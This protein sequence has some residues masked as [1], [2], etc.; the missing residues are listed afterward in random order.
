MVEE[1]KEKTGVQSEE[2][3]NIQEI[4]FRYLIHW[5][6]FVV[7]VIVCVALAWG[8][9]RLTT[10]VYNISATVLIKDEK[11]G[12]GANM[13][14]ELEKMG[15]N[16]FV[17]SSSNIE[18]EIEVLKSRT[19]AREVVSSLGLFVTY[20]DEDKFP[21]KELYRTSPVL[22]SLTPQEADRLPQ[23]MEID[24]LLQP[25]GAMDVQVKVGKK[26]YRKHLEKLPA[27]FPTDEG[28]VA[29]FANNDTLSSLR[30]ESVTTERHITAY[31]NRPFAVAKGYAGSLLITPTSKATSVVTVSLKNS[32]TQRGKDYIDKLLEMYNINANNDKNEVA[33]RTG[34]FIDE[35]ID[36]ISK[37]L[38]STERD[39]EN[40]K[41]SAGITDL[42]SEA[43]IALTGNAEYEKK[44]VE[45]QTQ[46]NLVM[47]L[48]KYLQ[49]SEYEVLPANVGL[50][51]AGVAGAID[52]YNEMVA[53]RKRLLRTST[54][55]NPAIVNLTTSIRAMRS[56]IQTTLDA[57]LKGL[58]ITKAD[59]IREASRYSRRISDAPTQE[60]Q[61]VSIARQQ[62]IKSGLYLMLLQKREENAI[63][64][65]AIANNAKIIDEAQADSTPI[66][67][68]RMT[69]YLAAL[70]FGIGIPVGVIYLIGLTKFKIE[71]R[72]DV[73]KL[74]S[75]PVVGD[76]PLADEK[77]GAIAVFENQN[78]LM[79]ETFRNVRTNLQFMLENG[80]NVIL[81][82]STVS[83]EGKSFISA[84]L[85]ISL[86]LLG[87]KVVIV[88]LDIRKPGLNKVFNLPKKEYGITQFLT[89]STVNLMDLVHHSD[90]NKNLYI[91]P[92]GT[93][94][95]N[96]TE[97]LA[98][99]GLEKAVEIL[100]KNFDYVIL[101]TAP[102]G[103]VTDT[104]LIGRVADLS[105][106]VCRA[107]Y[108]RKTEFTLINELAENNKLPN[109][110]IV[111]NG[112]DL[113]KKKYGY[114]YGYG[115]YGKYYG[116]GKHYGYGEYKIKY[117]AN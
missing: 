61:F 17:S 88:G 40:F 52:R 47:D 39:L 79:S 38:G 87:K 37:E 91:L 106:Y 71:G 19:L 33:Q 14:S 94:P 63:V 74:T 104:L 103:M 57:T 117:K 27:V 56:N 105:V 76:I 81:V 89:N 69:I 86:S 3:I 115:K 110:C 23:T 77:M 41:R 44:R 54:E 93:V 36:I 99:D 21:N 43:Q 82:T 112:L 73:E 30:P 65:A 64:L 5:P 32:N 10:P 97:L 58:E 95:P 49:G 66:S 50:Q 4:L 68:K 34:E 75:L 60:R 18:N 62:E 55:S 9:L 45:N 70:V 12:G 59:L 96:P 102:V 84:N 113:Q 114:Y 28:T 31:I 6:W 11:K 67:P 15:L 51:D 29:F 13:S 46:I 8:Y 72:A 101:D 22:V 26:E 78:N 42:T 90:I 7:S 83:G 108:T 107:D 100:R 98:R 16:G 85:A 25:A 24:M 35:R 92:G 1:R 109:L 80:K 2:Q 20:M 48:K 53:E 111:I 116:Y